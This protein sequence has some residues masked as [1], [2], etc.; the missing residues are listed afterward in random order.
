MKQKIKKNIGFLWSYHRYL[1]QGAPKGEF[2][3]S[4]SPS[5]PARYILHGLIKEEKRDMIPQAI[6]FFVSLW[7]I[8]TMRYLVN[9]TWFDSIAQ[10]SCLLKPKIH[11]AYAISHIRPLTNFK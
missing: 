9:Q 10:T 5:S 2:D 8:Y 7:S 3:S 4:I 1:A 6:A 11:G